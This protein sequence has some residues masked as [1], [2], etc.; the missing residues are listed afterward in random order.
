[1]TFEEYWSVAN[2]STQ[3]P[4]FSGA[5]N[6]AHQAWLAAMAVMQSRLHAMQEENSRLKDEIENLKKLNPPFTHGQS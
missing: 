1:M 2:A 6:Q 3:Y 4:Q 5:Y